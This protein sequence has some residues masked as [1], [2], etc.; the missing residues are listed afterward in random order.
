MSGKITHDL[1]LVG[2]RQIG[3]NVFPQ[4]RFH[5]RRQELENLTVYAS[6]SCQIP[7]IA[8]LFGYQS[9][10]IISNTLDQSFFSF[11]FGVMLF[12]ESSNRAI[13]TAALIESTRCSPEFFRCFQSGFFG[14][15]AFY[16]FYSVACYF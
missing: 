13:P 11:Q 2:L 8:V 15:M 16:L 12:S 14:D 6:V 9:I 1:R 5:L 10:D 4:L 3:R 7:F